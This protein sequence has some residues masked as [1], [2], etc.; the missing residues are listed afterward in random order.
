MSDIE[1]TLGAVAYAIEKPN[2]I[3]EQWMPKLANETGDDFTPSAGRGHRRKF[4]VSMIARLAVMR[5]MIENGCPIVSAQAI[6]L[7][8]INVTGA[9]NRNDLLAHWWIR[10]MGEPHFYG[11]V[12]PNGAQLRWW[13]IEGELGFQHGDETT[14]SLTPIGPIVA[15]ALNRLGE[16]NETR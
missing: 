13:E 2:K 1:H 14:V 8:I 16:F 5:H 15:K 9:T 4:S 10:D 3:V 6:A 12:I 7:S 11:R